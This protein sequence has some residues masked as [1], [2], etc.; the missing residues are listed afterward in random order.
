MKTRLLILGVAVATLAGCASITQTA[1]TSGSGTNAVRRT[2]LQVRSLG[3]SKQI[4]ERLKASNGATH[5]LGASGI[6]QETTSQALESAVR[7]AVEAAI[8]A[9]KKP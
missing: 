5:S 3:D 8:G 1:E 4:V 7:G 6:E 9:A 2:T